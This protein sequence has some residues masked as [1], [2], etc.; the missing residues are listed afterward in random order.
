M[1]KW[2]RDGE[3]PI[4]RLVKTYPADDFGRAIADMNSGETVKPVLIWG[5]TSVR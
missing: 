3:F 5:N 4:D 1:I 2:Y